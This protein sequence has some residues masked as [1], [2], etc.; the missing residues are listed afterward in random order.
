MRLHCAAL[1]YGLLQF[2]ASVLRGWTGGAIL[3]RDLLAL[4]LLPL[5]LPNVGLTIL[6]G[7]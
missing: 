1:R 5:L 4:P 7:L 6:V 3:F 2:R